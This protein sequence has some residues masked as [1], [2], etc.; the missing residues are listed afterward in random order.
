MYLYG[1]M[2]LSRQSRGLLLFRSFQSYEAVESTG[3]HYSTSLLVL[4]LCLHTPTRQLLAAHPKSYLLKI[5][6]DHPDVL[7][8]FA[9]RAS[10]LIPYSQEALGLLMNYRCMSISDEGRLKTRPRRVAT[11]FAGTAE[12]M[13]CQNIARKVGR[14]F[15]RVGDRVT[16]YTTFG[17]RP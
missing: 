7:V 15:A 12:I 2:P 4:P 5:V 17:V 16:I 14:D 6:E 11:S 10:D 3:M 13:E 8:G 9:S 1:Q